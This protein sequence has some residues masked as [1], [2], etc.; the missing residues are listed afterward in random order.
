M[1]G[2]NRKENHLNDAE[3]ADTQLLPKPSS[4]TNRINSSQWRKKKAFFYVFDE[5][6]I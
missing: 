4:Q 5:F 1:L 2:Y 3:N 6:S